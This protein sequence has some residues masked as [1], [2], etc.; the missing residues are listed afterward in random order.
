M[1]TIKVGLVEDQKLFREGIKVLI[2]TDEELD[3]TFESPDGYSVMDRLLESDHIPDVMLIDLSLPQNGAQ[4]FN[5][6]QVLSTLNQH[7][8]EM[9][10]LILSVNNDPYVIAQLIENGAHGYLAKDIEPQEVIDG[11]KSVVKNGSYIN[12]LALSAIQH[13]MS[14]A[15]NEPIEH[16][17]LTKREIEVVQL[18]AQG[19]PTHEIAEEL[20]ISEKT[21]NGHRNNILQKTGCRNAAGLVMYAV[22]HNIVEIT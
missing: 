10:K 8:P 4:E 9:R 2:N 19:K 21:V 17:D 6:W 20:F 7:Y 14:G 1:N 11:I 13:K 3:I 22:R 5:G 15:L 12:A 18:V 16:K